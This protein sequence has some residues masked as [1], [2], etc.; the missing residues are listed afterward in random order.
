MVMFAAIPWLIPLTRGKTAQVTDG[1]R[2]L[3]PAQAVA[4][5]PAGPVVSAGQPKD[6]PMWSR[7]SQPTSATTSTGAVKP[8]ESGSVVAKGST[9]STCRANGPGLAS[10]VTPDWNR[11]RAPRRRPRML[12]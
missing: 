11:V 12:A 1:D 10:T 4:A 6:W 8:V 9:R 5:E 7:S 2:G 3:G